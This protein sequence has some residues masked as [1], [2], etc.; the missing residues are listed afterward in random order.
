LNK[1]PEADALRISGVMDARYIVSP[2]EL[3]LPVVQHGADVT[4]Y[5]NDAAAGRAWIV[6]QPQVVSDS[7]A[8][9]ADPSFDPRQVVQISNTK[10]QIPKGGM[11]GAIGA[12][13]SL[14]DSPNAVTI[15]AESGSGGFL[16]LADTFY[17]GWQA[18][19]DGT[20]VEI[21]R[22][23]HAFRAVVFPPG[24]HTVVFRYEP[25]SFRVGSAMS[26]LGLIVVLVGLVLPLQRRAGMA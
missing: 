4:V 6:S 15:R 14:Q 11:T 2:R 25:L 17:P 18:T 3:S 8:A 21:L 9:L 5:R 23:N 12:I 7:V 20:P 13:Q 16:V 26:L 19:M 10:Y 1:S 22:A 24:K